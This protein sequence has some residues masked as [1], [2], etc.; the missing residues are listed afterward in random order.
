MPSVDVLG[1]LN[2]DAVG[3]EIAIIIGDVDGDALARLSL[4]DELAEPDLG[5]SLAGCA[6]GWTVKRKILWGENGPRRVSGAL[7]IAF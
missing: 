4:P 1:H 5:K 3:S 2:G 6:S 7:Y